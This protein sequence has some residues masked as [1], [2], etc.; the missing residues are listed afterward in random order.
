MDG[1]L[2]ASYRK[3]AKDTGVIA[4]GNLSTYNSILGFKSMYVQFWKIFLDTHVTDNGNDNKIGLESG[5]EPLA[6]FQALS[7][8]GGSK[9]NN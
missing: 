4:F 8:K 2:G 5:R 9:Q 6:G 7:M 3:I 1:T